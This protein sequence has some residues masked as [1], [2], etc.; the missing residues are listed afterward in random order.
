MHSKSA[1][2][3]SPVDFNDPRFSQMISTNENQIDMYKMQ[4]KLLKKLKN[5]RK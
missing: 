4:Q 2:I 1:H 3:S 5:S